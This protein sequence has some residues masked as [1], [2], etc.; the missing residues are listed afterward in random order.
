MTDG[1]PG[2][3]TGPRDGTDGSPPPPV[4]RWVKV[5]AVMALVVV[6]LLLAAM[7]LAG[8]EHGPGRHT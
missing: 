6:L 3:G 8:G 1:A 5:G 7:V 2:T 4:P